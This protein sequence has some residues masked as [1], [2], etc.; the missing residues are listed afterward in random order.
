MKPE[1]YL[2]RTFVIKFG[3]E[4]KTGD[5]YWQVARFIAVID[6]ETEFSNSKNSVPV[7]TKMVL[8]PSPDQERA[9][10]KQGTDRLQGSGNI[11]ER[12]RIQHRFHPIGFFR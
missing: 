8:V 1:R 11:S 6:Q 10:V 3:L 7:P 2:T 4:N 9:I 5:L 12:S